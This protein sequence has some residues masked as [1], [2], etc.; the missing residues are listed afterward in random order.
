MD[1][2]IEKAIETPYGTKTIAVHAMDLNNLDEELDVMTVSAFF[3]SYSP[4]AG[5]MMETLLK[6]GIS[7][8]QLS[9]D[10]EI[11]LRENANIWLSR[12]IEEADLPI[13]HVGCIEMSPVSYDRNAWRQRQTDIL[14]SIRA[15]FHML[16]IASL[17]GMKIETLGLPILGSGMQKI[18]SDLIMIPVLNECVNFLQTNEQIRKIHIIARSQK[19]TYQFAKTLDQS[20]A[21]TENVSAHPQRQFLEAN[22]SLAFISYSSK[23]KNIADNL[24]ARLENNGIRVWYAP[25]DIQTNDYATAI[26]NA[27]KRSTHFIV[28]LSKNSL[29]SQH[30]LN[31]INLAFSELNRGIH[32]KP[33]KIDE[34]ELGAAFV[35]YL[36]RQHWMDAH[37]PPLEKRL[38]EFVQKVLTDKE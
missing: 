28:I 17:S 5:T 10:P 29:N 27:I 32:F 13:R 18:S 20:Y 6:K 30:V 7:V 4:N 9:K 25:R 14:H 35:Y 23:D 38:D 11:D 37:I 33:L 16:Q 12:E 3:H 26:V 31:E 22:G 2:L 36:S 8:W 19:L 24:C 1:K 21:L 15:Y 34:E